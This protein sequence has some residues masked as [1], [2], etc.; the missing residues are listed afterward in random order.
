[1][2]ELN[3]S[4]DPKRLARLLA[5]AMTVA[6]LSGR[7][8]VLDEAREATDGRIFRPKL[9][10]SFSS[11]GDRHGRLGRGDAESKYVPGGA[12]REAPH[13]EPS[14]V[15][16]GS[17]PTH[18]RETSDPKNSRFTAEGSR[19]TRP[20]GLMKPGGAPP[21][22]FADAAEILTP[23]KLA[24]VEALAFFR[25][26]IGM[27]RKAFDKLQRRYRE[28]AFTIANVESVRL[29]EKVKGVLDEVLAE[30][31]TRRVFLDRANAELRSAGVTLSAFHLETVFETNANSAYQAGRAHQLLQADVR[32][33]LPFWQYKTAADDRVRPNHRALHN[34]IA[35]SDDAVWSRIYP[36]NGFRCRCSVIGRT[37]QQAGR[38]AG[39][40][41]IDLRKAGRNRL[42]AGPDEGFD[43]SPVAHF[44]K[45][46]EESRNMNL[47]DFMAWAEAA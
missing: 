21:W 17:S 6:D 29:I 42:P 25:Q 10:P 40:L 28:V 44:E 24:P 9:G 38:E 20:A 30:G 27:T 46:L 3:I 15:N 16:R 22:L 11:G 35:R 31:Q 45:R 36:P 19:P 12:R 23:E 4:L 26:K 39:R 41:R 43:T 8:K 47:D 1:M 7:A 13:F 2:P 33:A 18:Q 37:R 34:F 5:L 14:A 32:R